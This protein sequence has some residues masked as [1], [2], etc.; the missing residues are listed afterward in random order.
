MRTEQLKYLVDVAETG[1]M[2]KSADRLFV[3]PQAV[4][5]AI[6]QLEEEL[7]AELLVRTRLGVTL[8][9][10][11]ESIV[12]LAQNMLLE[13]IVTVAGTEDAVISFYK[14]GEFT[15]LCAGPHLHSTGAIKAFKLTQCTGAYYKGDQNNKMLQRVYGI[16]F[17]TKDELN[18]YVEML[19]EARKRD[20]NKIGRDLEYFTPVDVIGQRADALPDLLDLRIEPCETLARLLEVLCSLRLVNGL[21]LLCIPSVGPVGRVVFISGLLD[22]ISEELALFVRFIERVFLQAARSP[23]VPWEEVL[24]KCGKCSVFGGFYRGADVNIFA[25]ENT[26]LLFVLRDVVF[27]AFYVRP[28]L[29]LAS[30]FFGFIIGL[31]LAFASALASR[32]F[33]TDPGPL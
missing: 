8:T 29:R 26:E 7:G 3:S 12:A 20:H 13:E 24:F 23:R 22:I 2:N 1:S 4:S 15:D 6:K 33:A 27:D 9:N 19:E 28:A 17:P 10:V 16:A 31:L 14:Q 5:K 11:G 30:F 25:K 21:L 32:S 18:A